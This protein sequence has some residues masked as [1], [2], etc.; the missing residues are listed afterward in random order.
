MI[1]T[2]E[3]AVESSILVWLGENKLDFV[4]LLHVKLYILWMNAIR[5]IT[6]MNTGAYTL[7]GLIVQAIPNANN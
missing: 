6:A 3:I 5:D 4:K 7:V 1:Q 2:V